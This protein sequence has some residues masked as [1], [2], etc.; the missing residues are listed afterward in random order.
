MTSR[1]PSR[2]SPARGARREPAG[3]PALR[4]LPPVIDAGIETLILGSFPSP[5]SLGAR[6]YYAHPRNHFW[7]ILGLALGEPLVELPYRERLERVLAHGIGIWD[8]L[9][10]CD[11]EGSLDAA[12]R[13]RVP[14]DFARLRRRAPALRLVLFNGTTAGRHAPDL[15]AAG[16]ATVVLPSTSPAHA[17]IDPAVRRG[18]WVDALARHRAPPVASDAR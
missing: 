11:R 5:A 9:G 3:A 1:A 15:A 17:S 13:N 7:P 6:Q 14:N 10:A 2:M 4:G 18:R 16:Y 12:I 8:V